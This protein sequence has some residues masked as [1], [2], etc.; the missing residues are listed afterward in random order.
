MGDLQFVVFLFFLVIFF[1]CVYR[2]HP[3]KTRVTDYESS[4]EENQ[5]PS[6]SASRQAWN[7]AVQ[8][9]YTPDSEIKLIL[10]DNYDTTPGAPVLCPDIPPWRACNLYEQSTI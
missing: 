6:N 1:V 8:V 7:N 10:L 5:P 2:L 4:D 9:N 3:G